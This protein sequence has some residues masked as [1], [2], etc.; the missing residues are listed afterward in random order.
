MSCRH[1]QTILAALFGGTKSLLETEQHKLSFL[2]VTHF[3]FMMTLLPPL[4]R[5]SY[6]LV[7]GLGGLRHVVPDTTGNVF[8]KITR[9]YFE[10]IC[11]C[12]LA[13]CG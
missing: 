6:L 7:H 2:M 4:H 1:R 13:F 12:G 9:E 3:S 5:I 8:V 11:G 10:W